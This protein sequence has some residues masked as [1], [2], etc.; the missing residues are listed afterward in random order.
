MGRPLGSKNKKS[1]AKSPTPLE[2]KPTATPASAKTDVRPTMGVLTALENLAHAL[3]SDGALSPLTIDDLE[4][5]NQLGVSLQAEAKDEAAKRL[6]AH[7]TSM[8]RLRTLAN[9]AINGTALS[10]DNG[11][12]PAA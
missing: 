5:L 8:D 2:P 3:A 4:A 1:L 10:T 7:D 11:L 6:A 9:T 12:H